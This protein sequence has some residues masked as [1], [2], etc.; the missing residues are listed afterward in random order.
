M[1]NNSERPYSSLLSGIFPD[2]VTQIAHQG[3]PNL[4]GKR[5]LAEFQQQQ[6]LQFLQLQQ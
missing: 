4:M 2:L 1:N 5:S 6:Q 3:R